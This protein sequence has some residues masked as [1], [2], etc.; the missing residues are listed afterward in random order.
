MKNKYIFLGEIESINTELIVNSFKFLKNK[1]RYI[2]IGDLDLFK[3][4]SKYFKNT[5]RIKDIANPYDFKNLNSNEINFFHLAPKKTKIDNMIAQIELCN[6]LSNETGNDLI[7]LPINK[8]LFK[9]KLKFN[10]MTEYLGELNNAKTTM[11]MTGENF[12]IIPIT[13]HINLKNIGKGFVY[14]IENFFKVLNQI[15]ITKN[16]FYNYED[17]MFLCFNP[18]CSENRTLGDEDL[19]IKRYLKNFKSYKF[20]LVPADSAFIKIKKKTLFISYY[21]DQALI[22]FKILNKKSF[23]QTLGLNYRRLSPSH[24]TALDIRFKNLADNTSYIQCMID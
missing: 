12:S 17:F 18:H 5:P 4:D 6:Y 2:I 15:N 20:K 13:T 23:N 1:V 19:I 3:R 14:K 11:L 24:G 7:T 21:H 16:Y 10:G 8:S 9:K 22:P